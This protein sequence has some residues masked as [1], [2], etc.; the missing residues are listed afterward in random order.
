PGE[1][2]PRVTVRAARPLDGLTSNA[3]LRMEIALADQSG[4]TALADLFADAKGGRGEVH[5]LVAAG[6][7]QVR[8]RI[9]RDF[10]LDGELVEAIERMPGVSTVQLDPLESPRL[11]LVS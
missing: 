2:T 9:G 5:L 7:E 10:R 6:D 8:L 3:R 1:E 4:L 11:A